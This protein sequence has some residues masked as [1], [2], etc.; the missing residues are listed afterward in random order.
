MD[1]TAIIGVGM[2][3]I[4]ANKRSDTFADM[5]WEAVNLALTDAGITIDEIDNVVT[6]SNDFWDGR[7]IS[8]MAVSDVSGARGKNASCVEGDGTFGAFYGLTRILS[9]AYGTTLVT[10]HSKGSESV[11]SLIT[12]AAFDP[13][14]ERALGLDMITACAMQARAYMHRTG[15]TSEQLAGVSVKNHGNARKN[16]LSQF[17]MALSVADVL[18]SAM[19]ADPLHK[20]DCAPVSDACCALVMASE[21]RAVRYPAKPVWIKGVSFCADAYHLGDR[22]LSQAPSLK[23]AAQNAFKMAGV[24]NPSGEMDVAEVYDAFTYQELMWLEAMG[25]CEDSRA[26]ILL[27]KGVFDLNGR[28]PVN[29]SGG[30]LSGHPVIAAGLI[31]LAEIVKQLRGEA[32]AYQVG[33]ARRGVAQGVNG[34]CGQSHCVWVLD[35]EK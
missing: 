1:H 35:K 21:E 34:L 5:A 33:G 12:N 30:L 24:T 14:Y 29:P 18:K 23:Q 3:R 27:E 4:E 2:T 9:G 15:T 16:P 31:R 7:T 19:I 17:P 8:C 6:T 32:G 28:L 22:D 25:L 11:S 20:L 13:I 10:A 26:G